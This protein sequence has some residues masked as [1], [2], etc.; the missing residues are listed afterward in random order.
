MFSSAAS[1]SFQLD[2][3][4]GGTWYAEL[5][6]KQG[7]AN[8]FSFSNTAVQATTSGEIGKEAKLTIY[9]TAE[10]FGAETENVA[11]LRITARGTIGGVTRT[12][13]VDMG[14]AGNYQ[15]KQAN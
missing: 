11:E 5:I 7:K 12:F 9:T 2:A 6:T 15:I 4:V 8:A 3:P 14:T 10:N 1:F 13:R